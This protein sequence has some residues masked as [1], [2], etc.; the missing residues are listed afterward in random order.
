VSRWPDTRE[1]VQP[2]NDSPWYS[3][4]WLVGRHQSV[5]RLLVRVP[6]AISWEDHEPWVEVENLADATNALDSYRAA[7][8][9]YRATSFEPEQEDRWAVWDAAG[10]SIDDFC[11]PPL[12]PTVSGIAVLSRTEQTRLRLLA[13]L[14]DTRVLFSLNDLSGFDPEGQR[15]VIDWFALILRR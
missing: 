1:Q 13:T 6:G 5:Q 12:R 8:G 15:F 14:G 11:K 4:R 9:A 10:P 7:W 3:A 2:E